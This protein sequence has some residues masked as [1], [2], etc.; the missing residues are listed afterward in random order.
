MPRAKTVKATATQPRDSARNQKAKE[1][2][3]SGMSVS[4]HFSPAVAHVQS[5]MP[6]PLKIPCPCGRPDRGEHYVSV[7]TAYSHVSKQKKAERL[8]QYTSLKAPSLKRMY[9]PSF[10]VNWGITRTRAAAGASR[11][12]AP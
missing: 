5:R 11:I 6:G 9:S 10:W 12:R 4:V 1:P 3:G 8:G 7:K 2:A